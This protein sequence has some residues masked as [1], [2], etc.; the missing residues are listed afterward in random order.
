MTRAAVSM[1][2][3]CSWMRNAVTRWL[4]DG[5]VGRRW[6]TAVLTLMSLGER[7]GRM[8]MPVKGQNGLVRIHGE[9]IPFIGVLEGGLCF[10]Y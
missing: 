3:F 4:M 10:S 2:L 8:V 7:S 6:R 5:W 1:Q 9:I